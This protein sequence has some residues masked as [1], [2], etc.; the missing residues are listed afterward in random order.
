MLLLLM[1]PERFLQATVLA[2]RSAGLWHRE[3]GTLPWQRLNPGFQCPGPPRTLYIPAEE[4][5][6][7]P[8]VKGRM[9]PALSSSARLVLPPLTCHGTCLLRMFTG[10]Q[11]CCERFGE[12]L[13]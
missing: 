9:G 5:V 4:L 3:G 11:V 6:R 10:S 1:A 2:S 12:V 7:V 8:A 13:G